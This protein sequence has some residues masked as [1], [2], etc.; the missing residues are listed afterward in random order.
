MAAASGS[1]RP[2]K[3]RSSDPPIA[4]LASVPASLE[5]SPSHGWNPTLTSRVELTTESVEYEGVRNRPTGAVVAAAADEELQIWNVGGR[6]DSNYVSNRR[7][8]HPGTRVRVDAKLRL[9]AKFLRSKPG[10]AFA[11]RLLAGLRSQ[12]YWPFRNC[13]EDIARTH[14]NPGGKTELRLTVD[15]SGFVSQSRLLKTDLKQRSIALCHAAEARRLRVEPSRLR[16]IDVDVT[17][18]VW[19]GDV[20]L[21]SLPTA[22]V[23]NGRE[24]LSLV[25]RSIRSIEPEIL[26]CMHAARQHDPRL[27]G[28]LSLSFVIDPA[29]HPSG[30]AESQSSFGAHEAIECVAERLQSLEFALPRLQGSRLTAAWRLH[31]PDELPPPLDG[32]SPRPLPIEPKAQPPA[33]S[34]PQSEELA[35]PPIIDQPSPADQP[36]NS[37]TL[38]RLRP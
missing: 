25:T 5:E 7:G 20:P 4:G 6:G 38:P 2:L 17:V 10:S 19:P 24:D 31:R 30:L 9:G 11:Q 37:A 3:S 23:G 15:G 21:L 29:G 34:P 36:G 8:Y 22:M 1:R 18:A 13:F 35:T 32:A 26:A 33:S 16:R 12:G 27:W 14:R 28:R